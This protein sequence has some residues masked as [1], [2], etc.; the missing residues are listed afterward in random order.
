MPNSKPPAITSGIIASSNAACPA[1][2]SPADAI[3]QSATPS[4]TSSSVSAAGISAILDF[5]GQFPVQ[6]R[7]SKIQNSRDRPGGQQVARQRDM[8]RQPGHLFASPRE[9]DQRT[10][11]PKRQ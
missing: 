9:R 11:E 10:N 3:R 4:A 8:Y 7:K 5:G 6:N 2:P 1:W